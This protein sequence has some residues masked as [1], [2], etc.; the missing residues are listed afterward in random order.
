M[1]RPLCFLASRA[2][3]VA[4][5]AEY[6]SVLA[7]TGLSETE[8]VRVR[9]D[10]GDRVGDITG[11][12]GVIL[13]G[14]PFTVSTPELEKSPVQRAVEATLLD[15]LDDVARH[16]VPFLGLCYG[17]GVVGR[18]AGGEVDSTYAENTSAVEITL[19][20]AGRTDPLLADLPDRFDAYVGHK[21]A[22]TTTPPGAVVLAS[23]PECPVQMYRFGPGQYV[24][25]FHPEMDADAVRLRIEVYANSGYFAPDAV[26]EVIE[27]TA[28]AD[29]SAA[30]QV[31]RAFAQW[32]GAGADS[33]RREDLAVQARPQLPV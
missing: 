10:R 16:Q 20:E 13:G 17:V 19:T 25:Q 11:Y 23:A 9:L 31:L 24:T 28:Q 1:N 12:A 21:E 18:W 26:A 14:S 3:D 2:E 29:V 30:H 33:G 22:C 15:V 6:A 27:R 7:H 4:A 5:D 8:L 32:C